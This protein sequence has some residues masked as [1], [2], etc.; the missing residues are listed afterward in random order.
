[1][2]DCKQCNSN[3]WKNH[4]MMAQKRFDKV[5]TRLAI[6]TVLAFFIVVGCLV[7]TICALLKFQA[8]ISEFEYVEETT[9]EISQDRDGINTAIIGNENEVVWNGTNDYRKS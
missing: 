9:Y 6:G 7:A 4:Y 2:P 8:F 5:L 1:M 3:N